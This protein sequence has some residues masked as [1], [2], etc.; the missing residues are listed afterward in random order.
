MKKVPPIRRTISDL[1]VG[2]GVDLDH[3]KVGDGKMDLYM[4]MDWFK[5]KS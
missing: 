4:S 5:G 3:E 2:Y 1:D